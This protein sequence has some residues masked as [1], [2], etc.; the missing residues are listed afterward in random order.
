MQ[1]YID[2][3][4]HTTAS[5]HAY[6]TM[7]GMIRSAADKHMEVLAIT[8]HAPMMPGS[9]GELYFSNMKVLPREKYG[10]KIL[11]G[12]ELNIMDLEGRVDLPEY[13]LK[14]LDVVIAS[15]HTPCIASGTVEENTDCLIKVMDNPY[16]NII[17]HPDDARYPVDYERLV[18]AAGERHKLLELNNASLKPT[19]PRK[20]AYDNDI[21]MLTLCKKYGVAI[22]LGS[23]AHCEEA[24]GDFARAMEVVQTVDFPEKLIVNADYGLLKEYLKRRDS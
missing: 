3:H 24:V 10:V 19:G 13:I 8:D 21:E 14:R 2:M 5:G 22:S 9:C 11:Y 20:G 7:N 12:S 6:N 1:F 16:V 18:L 15:F 4:T 23:D 17:G